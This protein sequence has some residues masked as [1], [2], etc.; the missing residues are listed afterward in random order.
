MLPIVVFSNEKVV[1]QLKSGLDN[2][3]KTS[4][5]SEN[6]VEI[7]EF[8]K[9]LLLQQKAIVQNAKIDGI[10]II[11]GSCSAL[12]ECSI[13][14]VDSSNSKDVEIDSK[15]QYITCGMGAKDTITF[16]SISTREVCISILRMVRDVFGNEIDPFEVSL[17]L[18]DGAATYPPFVLLA[19]VAILTVLGVNLAGRRVV[20]K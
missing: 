1:G 9:V 14:I 8:S 12:V 3:V 4:I 2:F 20:L 13:A 16:S 11:C 6:A 7:L 17:L 15:S 19:I 18:E 10:A 5:F